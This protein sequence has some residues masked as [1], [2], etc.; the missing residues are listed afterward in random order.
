M[1]RPISPVLIGLL[2]TCVALHFVGGNAEANT[3]PIAALLETSIV[4]EDGTIVAYGGNGQWGQCINVFA[5]AGVA[6]GRVAGGFVESC[7]VFAV[8]DE[9]GNIYWTGGPCGGPCLGWAFQLNIFA[10]TSRPVSRVVDAWNSGVTW[11]ILTETGDVFFNENTSVRPWRYLGNAFG[12][13]TP[14][15]RTT[16]GGTKARYR[17]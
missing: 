4:L 14:T 3:S 12:S 6:P 15:I 8:V 5:S 16:W 9:G 11:S 10:A 1:V 2:L 13:A 17:K 7:G